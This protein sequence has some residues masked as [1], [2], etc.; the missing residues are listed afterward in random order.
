MEARVDPDLERA[1]AE[2]LAAADR[3]EI[4]RGW[5]A[6]HHPAHADSIGQALALARLSRTRIGGY[7]LLRVLGRGG[8]GTVHLAEPR[9]A[10]KILHRRVPLERFLSE[11]QVGRDIVH[12]NIVRTIDIGSEVRAGR[13]QLYLVFEY[14]EGRTPRGPLPVETCVSIGVQVANALGALHARG[15]LHRDLKPGNVL[16]TP[17]GTVKV[18]DYGVARLWPEAD[19][20]AGAFVGSPLYAAPEQ[21]WMPG[22]ELDGR[23]DLYSLGVLLFELATGLLPAGDEGPGVEPV[24]DAVVRTLLRVDRER[25]FATAEEVSRVL[26]E[27]RES[28]WWRR[29]ERRGG[30]VG[31]DQEL[32]ELHDRFRAASAGLGAAVVVT[33]AAGIGKT[34][35]LERFRAEVEAETWRLE[36]FDP[37]Y[38]EGY[39]HT[40]FRELSGDARHAALVKILRA[41]PQPRVVVLEDLHEGGLETFDALARAIEGERVLLIGT[42]RDPT[43]YPTLALG[44]LA[45]AAVREL[46]GPQAARVFAISEGNPLYVKTLLEVGVEER[47]LEELIARRRL[48]PREFWEC[49]SCAGLAFDADVIARACGVRADADRFDHPLTREVVYARADRTRWHAA[50]GRVTGDV[51]HRLLGGEEVP[52]EEVLEAL[53]SRQAREVIAMADLALPRL[54]G[55]AHLEATFLRANALAES[56]DREPAE[57]ALRETLDRA[58]AAGN[59][60]LAAR[61]R[62]ALIA[63]FG[64][65]A[66]LPEARRL[67]HEALHAAPDEATAFGALAALADVIR[68]MGRA[69]QAYV[70]ARRLRRRMRP[71]EGFRIARG[72]E[73]I[74]KAALAAGA[75]NEAIE[76]FTRVTREGDDPADLGAIIGA[77]GHLALALMRLGR[78]D[79][80]LRHA[81]RSRDLARAHGRRFP[82]AMVLGLIADL[83]VRAGRFGEGLAT[84]E[85]QYALSRDIGVREG[86]ARAAV[87]LGQTYAMLGW[88]REMDRWIDRAGECCAGTMHDSHYENLAAVRAYRKGDAAAGARH[89]A[90]AR[91]SAPRATLGADAH[92]AVAEARCHHDGGEFDLARAGY[93][94]ARDLA[95]RIEDWDLVVEAECGLA[96]LPGMD[97]APAARLLADLEEQVS[98]VTR[99]RARADL[100]EATGDDNHLLQARATLHALQSRVPAAVRGRLLDEVPLYR[101]IAEAATHLQPSA[102]AGP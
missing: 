95:R 30:L 28:A 23:A 31:R 19:A 13:R 69:R 34:A 37:G 14:V 60:R 81:R 16:V 76:A 25:R 18:M 65:S 66:R 43:R 102:P 78:S 71:S 56:L 3:E 4:T 26:A 54:S 32:A 42:S 38:L 92:Q 39:L 97:P 12:R 11:A 9:A 47:S 80:A 48:E 29:G 63:M 91:E 62:F 36:D 79:D 99:L 52:G 100:W 96:S 94:K 7:R 5:L 53:R 1:L 40:H 61:A 90:R 101:R 35:L 98:L 57:A 2:V 17:D 24:F 68:L 84:L 58:H 10:V 86:M 22:S 83:H 82:E 75:V 89:F 51:R 67:A 55:P 6:L 70:V 27:G 64:A 88:T 41:A 74:G 49:A 85:E 59:P 50:L 93:E 33:G 45:E 46:A 73:A 15:I 44:P 72:W 87:A 21:F 77:E 8:M 20:G